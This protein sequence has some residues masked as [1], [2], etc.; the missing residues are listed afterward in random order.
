[1]TT[2][3]TPPYSAPLAREARRT[4]LGAVGIHIGG[5]SCRAAAVLDSDAIWR[6]A[7]PPGE[8][9]DTCAMIVSAVRA[10]A[11]T[12]RF[13]VVGTPGHVDRENGTVSGAA[14]LGAEWGG[15]VPLAELLSAQ[16]QCPV[17][18]RNDAEVALEAERRKGALVAVNDGA[19][20]TLSTGVGVALLVDGHEQPT[21]LGHS[22][23]QFG[24]P[25]CTGRH[26]G[27]CF[28]SYL[29]GWALPQRYRERHPEF[30]GTA[31]REIPDDVEFWTDCGARL[32]ELVVS[33][34]LIGQRMEVVSFIGTVA[35]ARAR[36]LLPA[37]Q[38]RVTSESSLLSAVPRRMVLTPL[39]ED[40]AVI[41]SLLVARDMLYPFS[42]D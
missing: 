36:Y 18:L 19:L 35:L 27:G 20:V 4:H 32:A 31:A 16:L 13:V 22:V 23:L 37:V 33:L 24:G 5:T 12:P 11:P 9:H 6:G 30:T 1:M 29:G 7:L 40:V 3:T 21:E 25:P 34:C 42:G 28:E 15:L 17:E 26:H 41:G 38:A 2:S 14:N 10:V 39:G 8:V